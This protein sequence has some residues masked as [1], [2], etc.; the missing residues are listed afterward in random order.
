MIAGAVQIETERIIGEQRL[1]HP[2]G[3]FDDAFG[4]MPVDPLQHIDQI[5]VGV[6]T[7]QLAGGEQTLDRANALRD[8][9]RP[10]EQP[11]APAHRD[12]PQTRTDCL[13]VAPLV[14]GGV[15]MYQRG[16]VKMYHGRTS[17][18]HFGQKGSGY[19]RVS[20]SSS[21]LEATLF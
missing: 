8:E 15:I 14:N 9:F 6:H 16:G 11:V 17:S 7:L 5:G 21:F 4:R 13:A 10:G 12:R 19:K 18:E 3:Q 2:G 1:P 20:R